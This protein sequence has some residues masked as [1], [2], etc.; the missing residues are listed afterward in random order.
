MTE[1]EFQKEVVGLA[2]MLGW[3]VY[4]SYDS[5]RSTGKGFPDLVMVKP[6]RLLFIELKTETGKIKPEQF[7]WGRALSL[8]PGVEYAVWR[9]S[10]MTEIDRILGGMQNA[11]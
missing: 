9:P 3:K 5:R 11:S 10:Q 2:T 7:A 6:P 8:C 4:H 1:A